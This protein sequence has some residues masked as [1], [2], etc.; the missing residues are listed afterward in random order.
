MVRMPDEWRSA[1]LDNAIMAESSDDL[2]DSVKWLDRS[3]IL[4]LQAKLGHT[5]QVFDFA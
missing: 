5:S 3:G 4:L 2:M 1:G